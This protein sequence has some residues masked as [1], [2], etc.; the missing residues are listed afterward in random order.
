MSFE[1]SEK[2]DGANRADKVDENRQTGEYNK[3]ACKA[4]SKYLIEMAI[5]LPQPLRR[6]GAPDTPCGLAGWGL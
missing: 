4:F 6:R 3:K 2:I 1:L 5:G